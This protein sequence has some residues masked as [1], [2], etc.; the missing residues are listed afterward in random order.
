MAQK[1][2]NNLQKLFQKNMD[3][4]EFIAHV[5][6]GLLTV[7]GM[8]GLLKHLVEYGGNSNRQVSDGYG[9]SSYGGSRKK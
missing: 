2:Q 4:K 1:I 9:S 8:T 5:G 6:A 3:R 7:T